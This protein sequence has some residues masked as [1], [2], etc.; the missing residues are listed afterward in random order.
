VHGQYVGILTHCEWWQ[1]LFK[2]TCL[3]NAKDAQHFSA[4]IL[5]NCHE[6]FTSHCTRLKEL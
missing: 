5:F 6:T 2:W 3:V 1:L 4:E